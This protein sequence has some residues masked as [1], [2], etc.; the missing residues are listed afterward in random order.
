M[1]YYPSKPF[2][3]CSTKTALDD[4]TRQEIAKNARASQGVRHSTNL[5]LLADMLQDIIFYI[6]LDR[7]YNS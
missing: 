6:A 5:L 2:G 1:V 3:D 4:D 7:H